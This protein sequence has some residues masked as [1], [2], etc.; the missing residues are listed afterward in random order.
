MG[1]TSFALAL[2]YNAAYYTKTP[3]VIFSYEMSAIQLL[4]RLISMDSEISNRYI[5]NGTL[6]KEELI[7]LHKSNE[8]YEVFNKGSI[9]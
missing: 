1:K 7:K 8:T 2:A 4:R 6:G 5:T 3:T 9:K